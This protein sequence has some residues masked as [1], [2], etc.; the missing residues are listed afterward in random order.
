VPSVPFVATI[1]LAKR[2]SLDLDP[3]LPWWVI[4]GGFLLASVADALAGRE[5]RR[6]GR[7]WQPPVFDEVVARD[8]RK[9]VVYLR[10][11]KYESAALEE[12]LAAEVATLGP[13]CAVGTPG[14]NLRVLFFHHLYPEGTEWQPLVEDL[15]AAS[16][17]V[18][19]RTDVGGE[20]L[21]WE[22]ETVT[23]VVAPARLLLVVP[24]DPDRY[25]AF[26]SVFNERFNRGLPELGSKRGPL[27]GLVRF[28]T[29]WNPDYVD[30]AILRKSIGLF[31]PRR[32]RRVVAEALR[33]TLSALAV[34]RPKRWPLETFR[35]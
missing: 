8:R 21:H 26:R 27:G 13:A 5:I 1:D 24:Q 30:F 32:F 28:D 17:L 25:E 16:Q 33:P 15:V 4:V 19:V 18:L 22:V 12:A 3:S 9:P 35:R 20:G 34:P 23:R 2:Y 6:W 11:F 31:R 7:A 10:A 14:S 29:D